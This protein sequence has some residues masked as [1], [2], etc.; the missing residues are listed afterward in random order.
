MTQP[1]GFR[2]ASRRYKLVFW[3]SMGAYLAVFF[4]GVYLVDQETSPLA[5]RAGFAIAVALPLF[6]ALW[7]LL[8]HVNETDEYTRMRQLQALAEGGV[9]TT[10]AIFLVG[11]L[12]A[13]NAIADVPLFLFGAF[14]VAAYGLAYCRRQMGKTV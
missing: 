4:A 7:A 3:P 13:F 5:L 14:F 10:A 8:R 9:I 11:L 2:T 12:E 6:G 1:K